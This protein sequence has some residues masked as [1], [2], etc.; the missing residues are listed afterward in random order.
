MDGIANNAVSEYFNNLKLGGGKP[1][2]ETNQNESQ[3]VYNLE[4]LDRQR[5]SDP[6]EAG[7]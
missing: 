6:Y 4:Q 2:K 7:Q 5:I 3:K 1:E